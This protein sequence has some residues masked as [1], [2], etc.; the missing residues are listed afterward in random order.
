MC[1]VIT[2]ILMICYFQSESL[3]RIIIILLY[4]DDD[5]MYV[6]SHRWLTPHL[7]T[8]FMLIKVFC[9]VSMLNK[10]PPGVFEGEEGGGGQQAC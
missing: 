7:V 3:V 2:L 8:S 9:V 5:R 1:T 4:P 6:T 10:L